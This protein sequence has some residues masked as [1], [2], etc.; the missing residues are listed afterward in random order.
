MACVFAYGFQSAKTLLKTQAGTK[1]K[2]KLDKEAG[3]Q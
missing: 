2:K 3:E 1:L